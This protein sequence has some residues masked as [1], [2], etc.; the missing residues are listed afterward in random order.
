[1]ACKS[2]LAIVRW[3]Y[4]RRGNGRI[5]EISFFFSLQARRR[6]AHG[7]NPVSRVFWIPRT[8]K[9]NLR[10]MP[11]RDSILHDVENELRNVYKRLRKFVILGLISSSL[12][13][14]IYTQEYRGFKFSLYIIILARKIKLFLQANS[15]C[16]KQSSRKRTPPKK[17]R[18]FNQGYTQKKKWR[19]SLSMRCS[20][21]SGPMPG[22]STACNQNQPRARAASSLYIRPRSELYASRICVYIYTSRGEF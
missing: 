19:I 12:Y 14:I 3:S 5:S 22:A 15:V 10:L 9:R 6:R 2:S 16:R 11:H 17:G 20:S 18:S 7:E 21:I 4:Q 1:M 13:Y 8:Y